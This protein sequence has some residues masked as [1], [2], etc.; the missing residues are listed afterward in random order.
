MD[1]IIYDN[2]NGGELSLK[3]GDLEVTDGL[4]N[5]PYLSHFG[6]NLEASTTGNEEEN[7]ER[8]DWWGNEFLDPE[9]QMN[10]ELERALN[11]NALNSSGRINI[12][13]ASNKD[14]ESLSDLANVSSEVVITGNN[15]LKISDK[16]EKNVVN[17]LWDATKNELIEEIII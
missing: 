2:G 8:F 7:Q 15:K 3:N 10:S 5:M 1:L 4:L 17:M 12:E 14:L 11:E 13:R 6:G 16:I 9:N